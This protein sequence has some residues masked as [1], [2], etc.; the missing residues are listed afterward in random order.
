[1][2][3][4]D[5][6]QKALDAA[7]ERRKEIAELLVPAR[8]AVEADREAN[9][10]IRGAPTLSRRNKTAALKAAVSRLESDLLPGE[11]REVQAKPA[12][13]LA[14]S[15]RANAQHHADAETAPPGRLPR[16]ADAAANGHGGGAAAAG[17]DGG[18]DDDL[19]DERG[20]RRDA[21]DDE[22]G[23]PRVLTDL[24]IRQTFWSNDA[25]APAIA[26]M[27]NSASMD[28]PAF[29]AAC[30]D[31][32]GAVSILGMGSRLRSPST[33]TPPSTDRLRRAARRAVI[34]PTLV[35]GMKAPSGLA[36]P[37]PRWT[38]C[39]VSA[40]MPCTS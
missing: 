34:D 32:N 14:A 23:E 33:L 37:R 5:E 4:T 39:R 24:K 1:M 35:R 28:D 31:Y 36:S 21:V 10:G 12:G 13:F 8:A 22:G 17:D 20:R 11:H 2:S 7:V 38:S 27:V 26:I 25:N 18:G 3:A 40:K 29:K 16:D 9:K 15:A 19:G 30:L 6:A